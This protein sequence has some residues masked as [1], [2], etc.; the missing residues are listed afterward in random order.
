MKNIG[1]FYGN[2][3]GMQEMKKK[4]RILHIHKIESKSSKMV[5]AN[6]D[7]KNLTISYCYQSPFLARNIFVMLSILTS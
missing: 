5:P 6:K 7:A 1:D 4:E 2:M 3:C